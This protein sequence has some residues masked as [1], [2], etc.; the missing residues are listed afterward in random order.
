MT[1]LLDQL[2]LVPFRLSQNLETAF[3]Q[4]GDVADNGLCDLQTLVLHVIL[5]AELHQPQLFLFLPV[6]LM[7]LKSRVAFFLD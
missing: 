5:G 1:P 6:K 2:L 3:F 4:P 7:T